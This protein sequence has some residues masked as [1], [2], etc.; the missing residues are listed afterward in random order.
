VSREADLP[1][2]VQFLGS[3]GR[4]PASLNGGEDQADEKG[5]DG[6]HDENFE[7]RDTGPATF[8]C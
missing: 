6:H 8:H 7:Q 4:D 1:E 3:G 2:L 5:E